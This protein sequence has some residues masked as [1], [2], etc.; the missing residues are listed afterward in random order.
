[1]VK[2]VYYSFQDYLH[3]NPLRKKRS[4]QTDMKEKTALVKKEKAPIT[5]HTVSM[6]IS[7][8]SLNQ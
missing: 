7:N 2:I 4:Q 6:L 3:K 1:M 8:T 5:L